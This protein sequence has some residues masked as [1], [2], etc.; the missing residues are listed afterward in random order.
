MI[1]VI[2]D[3]KEK[4][5]TVADVN[6]YVKSIF[7]NDFNFRRISVTGEISNCNSRHASGHIFFSLKDASGKIDCV[8]YASRRNG[9]T[10]HL[11]D[12]LKVVV[13]GTISVYEQYGKYQLYASVIREDGKGALR[14]ELERLRRSLAAEGLFSDVHKK[15]IPYYSSKIGIV[16]AGTG[17]VIHDIMNVSR[18]RNPY[19]QLYLY[20]SLVQGDGAADSIVEGIKYLDN[21]GMDVI[22]VGRGGGS[23]ED[24]FAFN[25]EEVVRAVYECRTP[26]ISAVGHESD[27]TLAD[28]A[29]DLR[30]ST[31][32]AA[33]ELAVREISEIDA[34]LED[35]SR[36]LMKLLSGRMLLARKNYELIKTKLEHNTP[37]AK[38]GRRREKL[39][40]IKAG[41]DKCM[42][43][44]LNEYRNR[45]QLCIEKLKIL[46]PLQRLSGGYGYVRKEDGTAI[47]SIDMLETG[48]RFEVLVSDGRIIA[49]CAGKDSYDPQLNVSPQ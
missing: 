9:L 11:E 31:P 10:C 45:E 7:D 13:T 37:E 29:A 25:K 44:K 14:E 34:R 48:D 16:T 41:M 2:E 39:S 3:N 35:Y 12:G 42:T 21:L 4:V 23:F 28:Y 18:R 1:G 5:Y 33:A 36:E 43:D 40:L 46:S 27:T 19:V 22:I 38:L 47:T 20:P 49:E 17:A 26:I 24:L 6:R 8:M 30:A 32:S 15:K